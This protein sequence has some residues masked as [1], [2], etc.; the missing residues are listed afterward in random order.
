MLGRRYVK[1]RYDTS[2]DCSI[3][4]ENM[5]GRR[6]TVLPCAHAVH[7]KCYKGLCQRRHTRCP[8]C[9]APF[10]TGEPEEGAEEGAEEEEES[11]DWEAVLDSLLET[12]HADTLRRAIDDRIHGRPRRTTRRSLEPVFASMEDVD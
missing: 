3:C 5:F 4:L 7:V 10:A 9:R 11:F 6:A 2:E 12:Y 1:L 8:L